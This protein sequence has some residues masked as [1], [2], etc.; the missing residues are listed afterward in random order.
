M[1]DD[2]ATNGSGLAA[3]RVRRLAQVDALRAGGT[4]P[5][6]YRFDRTHTVAEVRSAWGEMAVGA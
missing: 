4:E 1:S 5:Y 6:P 3:E 2:P